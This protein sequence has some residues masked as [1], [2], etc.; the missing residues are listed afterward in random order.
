MEAKRQFGAS[1]LKVR[2][3]RIMKIAVS[4]ICNAVDVILSLNPKQ[5]QHHQTNRSSLAA[6]NQIYPCQ[7]IIISSVIW[8]VWHCYMIKAIAMTDIEDTASQLSA[9]KKTYSLNII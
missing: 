4:V 8:L 3:R 1:H 2:F 7:P 6:P 5:L 9:L